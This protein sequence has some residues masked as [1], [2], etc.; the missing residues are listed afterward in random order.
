MTIRCLTLAERQVLI[1]N[2]WFW[3]SNAAILR[4]RAGLKCEIMI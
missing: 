2:C 1:R 3:D 4:A